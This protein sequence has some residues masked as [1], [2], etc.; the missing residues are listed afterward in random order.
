MSPTR[1]LRLPNNRGI[2]AGKR[3]VDELGK[4]KR[5]TLGRILL[6]DLATTGSVEVANESREGS[7]REK[8]KEGGKREKKR[9]RKVGIN[10]SVGTPLWVW[11]NHGTA[12]RGKDV[13]KRRRARRGGE[14]GGKERAETG[15]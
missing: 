3:Q 8:R 5:K 9:E 10:E 13:R 12:D 4:S 6:L 1:N 14:G 2:E 7:R 15:E 11:L